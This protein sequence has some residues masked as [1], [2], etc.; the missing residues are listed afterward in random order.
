MVWYLNTRKWI[1]KF[2]SGAQLTTQLRDGCTKFEQEYTL[3]TFLAITYHSHTFLAI[4]YHSRP[5][6]IN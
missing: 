5:A 1:Q 4:T 6:S 2:F 3:F